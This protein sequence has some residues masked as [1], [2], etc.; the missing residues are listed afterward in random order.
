MDRLGYV[1]LSKAL[2]KC[3]GRTGYRVRTELDRYLTLKEHGSDCAAENLFHNFG[4]FLIVMHT[5]TLFLT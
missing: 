1:P 3:E 2:Q 4:L 5:E